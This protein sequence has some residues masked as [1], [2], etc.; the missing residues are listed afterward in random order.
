MLN[1]IRQPFDPLDTGDSPDT[2]PN[3]DRLHADKKQ[4]VMETDP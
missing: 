3:G 4:G 1:T 2:F